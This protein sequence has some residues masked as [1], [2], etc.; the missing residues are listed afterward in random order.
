MYPQDIEWSVQ[1]EFSAVR[2]GCIAV[3]ALPS[4]SG[5]PGEGLFY[6]IYV[7]C[8]LLLVEENGAYWDGST[9]PLLCSSV[10]MHAEQRLRAPQGPGVMSLGT[11]LLPRTDPFQD[12]LSTL[13]CQILYH[14]L[15]DDSHVGLVAEVYSCS[16][17]EAATLARNMAQHVEQEFSLTVSKVTL[18]EPR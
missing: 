11:R 18:I 10:C 5:D 1:E 13:Y 9:S 8:S 15:A 7:S 12:L 3:F 14:A 17:A 2:K 6:S 4:E 16:P